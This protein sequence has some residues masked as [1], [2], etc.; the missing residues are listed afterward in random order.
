M[1]ASP[2]VDVRDILDCDYKMMAQNVNMLFNRPNKFQKEAAQQVSPCKPL[3]LDI[4]REVT[5]LT[6]AVWAVLHITLCPP[7]NSVDPPEFFGGIPHKLF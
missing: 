5:T 2:K 3:P 4:L 1:H 7:G 6:R